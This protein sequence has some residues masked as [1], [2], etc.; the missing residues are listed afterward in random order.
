MN[1]AQNWTALAWA[2][3]WAFAITAGVITCLWLG[4]KIL[5]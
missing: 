1:L 2:F 5:R 3:L 4:R